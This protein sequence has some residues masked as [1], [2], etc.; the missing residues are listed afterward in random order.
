MKKALSTLTVVLVLSAFGC[1]NWNKYTPGSMDA[2][3]IASEIRKNQAADGITG[4]TVD[5]DKSGVV[6]LRGDVK[7]TTDRQKAIDDARKVNGVTQ[8]IDQISIKP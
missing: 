4:M 1:A 7:T 3:A 6:T 5:V 8:V 2:T